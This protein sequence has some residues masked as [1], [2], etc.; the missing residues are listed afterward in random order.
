[1]PKRNVEDSES[2]V[3]SAPLEPDVQVRRVGQ[4]CEMLTDGVREPSPC[5]KRLTRLL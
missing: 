2:M 3:E 4:Q 5:L 1:M